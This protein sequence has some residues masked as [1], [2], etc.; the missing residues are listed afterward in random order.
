MKLKEKAKPMGRFTV[1]L[2]VAN[3]DDVTLARHGVLRPDQVRRE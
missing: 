1:N 3:Y 2:E